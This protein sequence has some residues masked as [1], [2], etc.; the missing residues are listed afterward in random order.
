[1]KTLTA[2]ELK[3]AQ[4]QAAKEVIDQVLTEPDHAIA[5]IR[6]N[7]AM[8]RLPLRRIPVST[9]EPSQSAGMAKLIVRVDHLE[10]TLS[11]IVNMLENGMTEH[12]RKLAL[13]EIKHKH[14]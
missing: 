7:E 10:F 13:Q 8:E 1:M 12:A 4:D 11:R 6:H 3:A 9:P 14:V 2:G 5:I